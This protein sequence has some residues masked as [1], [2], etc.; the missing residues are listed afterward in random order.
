MGV[1]NSRRRRFPGRLPGSPVALL[2]L[3]LALA[4][5]SL[6]GDEASASAET[7][8]PTVRAASGIV[9]DRGTGVVLWQ[10]D[11]HSRRPPASL[12]KVMTAIVV[13][14]RVRDLD[15]WCTAPPGVGKHLVNVI[16]L[17]P[18][19]R[20]TVR[21]ALRAT[22]VKSAND[23]CLTLAHRVAGSEAAFVRLMNAKAASLGLDDTRFRNSRG[24]PVT[25][26]YMSADD[27]ARLGRYAM[28]DSRFRDL[29]RRRTAVI[30]WPGHAVRVESRN[31]LLRYD[32]A[33]GI[34]TGATRASGKC[35]LGS[36]RF[37]LRGLIVVTL[38]EPTREQEVRDAVAL[39]KWA[40]ALYERRLLASA[41]DLVTTVPLADGGEVRAVAASPLTRVVRRAAEVQV[42]V[43]LLASPL[44][45]VPEPGTRLGTVAF[46]ADGQL[47]G[48]VDLVADGTVAPSASP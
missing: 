31:R 35:L 13:L 41:G 4:A 20:I 17:R 24:K 23:A 22:I 30:R 15:S 16:G 45:D 28:S 32:W 36:G 11:P 19:E 44:G 12:T 48:T 43:T 38:R 37:D 5:S 46:R 27:L 10:K 40:D 39:F 42:E 2:V 18:G 14:E 34:K 29:C 6:A 1:P 26:H 9:V 47:L 33:N 8:A 25:G 3:L 7:P 21:Q